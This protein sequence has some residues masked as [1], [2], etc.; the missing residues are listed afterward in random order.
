MLILISPFLSVNI[1]L[2]QGGAS[3]LG[4]YILKI[5]ISSLVDPLIIMYCS[6][7]CLITVLILNPILSDVSIATLAFFYKEFFF[8]EKKDARS[9]EEH[10]KPKQCIKK[11]RHYFADKGPYSQSYGFPSSHV[12]I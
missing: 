9:L 10:G 7:L 8:T 1:C 4:A 5:V 3:I 12:Q 11:Q 2:T 6:S